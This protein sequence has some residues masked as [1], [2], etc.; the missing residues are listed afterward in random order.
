LR[1]NDLPRLTENQYLVLRTV[2][3]LQGAGYGDFIQ[4]K[5]RHDTGIMVPRA[6]LHRA[7]AS[8]LKLEAVTVE[9]G[10]LPERRGQRGRRSVRYYRITEEGRTILTNE[11]T[12]RR[13]V[14]LIR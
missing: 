9:S 4:R 5:I 12:P 3:V 7:L 13:R 10:T 6:T 14:G 2:D 8:F 11:T 1:F